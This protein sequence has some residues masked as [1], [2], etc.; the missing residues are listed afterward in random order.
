[1]NA[2]IVVFT[3][4]FI[5]AITAGA[6]FA[7]SYQESSCDHYILVDVPGPLGEGALW[8][9]TDQSIVVTETESYGLIG[10]ALVFGRAPFALGGVPLNNTWGCYY[11]GG[12]YPPQSRVDELTAG[13]APAECVFV[14]EFGHIVV[15]SPVDGKC[16]LPEP[17]PPTPTPVVTGTPVSTGTDTPTATLEPTATASLTPVPTEVPPTATLTPSRVTLSGGINTGDDGWHTAMSGDEL[18]VT[19]LLPFDFVVTLY[20]TDGDIVHVKM[21]AENVIPVVVFGQLVG[22]QTWQDGVWYFDL[23]IVGDKAEVVIYQLEPLELPGKSVNVSVNADGEEQVQSWV[24]IVTN[25]KN[26]KY[27]V[28]L[29]LI[30]R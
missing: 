19:T 24:A 26:G 5:A 17:P 20:G 16:I 14:G 4:L 29:P 23:E 22:E 7:E 3:V 6:V 8:L 1:M 12:Y 27:E 11:E 2:K 30:L 9:S 28:F 10:K 15:S 25:G 13:L 21:T 18:N